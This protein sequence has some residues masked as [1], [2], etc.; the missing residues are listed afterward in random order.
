MG[1]T[2]LD[3]KRFRELIDGV[4]RKGDIEEKFYELAVLVKH[5]V[6]EAVANLLE[7]DVATAREFIS[8]W[9][10]DGADTERIVAIGMRLHEERKEGRK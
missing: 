3:R 8:F 4:L 1:R 2:T 9:Q 5:D 7:V 6:I 10:S